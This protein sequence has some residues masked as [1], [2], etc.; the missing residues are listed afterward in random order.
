MLGNILG[1]LV[2]AV[3]GA[4]LLFN[5]YRRFRVLLPIWA[6][7]VG[8]GVIAGL[9]SAIFGQGFFS[10]ALTIIPGV[11]LG[12]IFATLSYLWYAFAVLFWAGIAPAP[13]AGRRVHRPAAAC[14]GWFC[15]SAPR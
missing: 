15:A 11:I 6:F 8:Y 3:I 5:G 10:T 1:A 14:R 7:L 13:G 12:V 9:L 4:A 2:L